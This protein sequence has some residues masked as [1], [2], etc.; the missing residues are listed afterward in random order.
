[1]MYNIK[2]AIFLKIYWELLFMSALCFIQSVN[3]LINHLILILKR[4]YFCYI[5]IYIPI[6]LYNYIYIYF[7]MTSMTKSYAIVALDNGNIS[8]IPIIWLITDGE[9]IF[10]NRN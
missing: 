8:S 4:I 10:E 2:H 3:I 9:I 5:Y 7:R 1:M 6:G